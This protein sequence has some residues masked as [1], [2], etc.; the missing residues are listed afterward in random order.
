MTK[1]TAKKPYTPFDPDF[2]FVCMPTKQFEELSE[3]VQKMESKLELISRYL[4]EHFEEHAKKS[5]PKGT[6]RVAVVKDKL[7]GTPR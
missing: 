2:S 6:S 7:P 4:G 5:K 1:K 3:K